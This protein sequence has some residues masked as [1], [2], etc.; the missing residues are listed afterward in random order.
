MRALNRTAL[1]PL[2]LLT[3]MLILVAMLLPLFPTAAVA[4]DG[5]IV[6]QPCAPDT[7][8]YPTET[9][10]QPSDIDLLTIGLLGLLQ[11]GI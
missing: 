11:S 3:L 4:G 5:G 1:L 7:T 9:S 10:M 8:T 6:L 2:S